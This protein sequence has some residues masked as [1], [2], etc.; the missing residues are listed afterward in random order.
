MRE[1]ASVILNGAQILNNN[2]PTDGGGVIWGGGYL[3]INEGTKISGNYCPGLAG[4]IRMVSSCNMTMNGGSITNNKTAS[5]GG[6]IWGS[7]KS[8]YNF[9]GGEMAYNEALGAGG[10]IYAGN[11]SVFNISGT[12]E[13]HDN[14]AKNSGAIRLTNGCQFIMTG[15]SFYNNV[16]TEDVSIYTWNAPVSMTG[17]TFADEMYVQNGNG[18]TIGKANITGI[19]HYDLGTAHNTAALASEFNA[20]RFT[21]NEGNANFASFNL[22]PA[23]GYVY[24]E[25]DEEKLICLNEGYTTYWDE[26]TSSF[27][28][29]AD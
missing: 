25:G 22:K 4:V 11:D 6:V 5:N 20:F 9:N 3:E 17:G 29:M 15:G 18:I 8:I 12:F 21:V 13:I 27:R 16:G 26:A 28:L 2:G 14:K 7:G 23:S 24:T 19:I 10:A 1:G